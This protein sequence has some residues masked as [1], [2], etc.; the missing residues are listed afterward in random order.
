MQA[1]CPI[2]KQQSLAIN[3]AGQINTH[4]MQLGPRGDSEAPVLVPPLE[5]NA[6]H[7]LTKHGHLMFITMMSPYMYKTT[8]TRHLPY[9]KSTHDTWMRTSAQNKLA[10]FA[11][12]QHKS[13]QK[14]KGV[15]SVLLV[16][17]LTQP[18]RTDRARLACDLRASELFDPSWTARDCASPTH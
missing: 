15:F 2:E 18:R 11:Q 17:N 14:T 3:Q 7:R 8:R 1:N 4:S 13:N 12:T 6:E 5:S 9:I 10:T 16:P